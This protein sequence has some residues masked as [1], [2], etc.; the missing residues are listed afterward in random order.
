V[1]GGPFDAAG[2]TLPL[3]VVKRNMTSHRAAPNA[4]S[5]TLRL[6]EMTIQNFSVYGAVTVHPQRAALVICSLEET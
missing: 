3:C 6:P 1:N 2:L 5:K 4:E